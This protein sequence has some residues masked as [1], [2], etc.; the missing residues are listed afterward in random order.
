MTVV[1]VRCLDSHEEEE[2]LEQWWRLMEHL[3]RSSPFKSTLNIT[4][5]PKAVEKNRGFKDCQMRGQTVTAEEQSCQV[6]DML[7]FMASF[8]PDIAASAVIPEAKSLDWIYEFLLEHYG[9]ERSNEDLMLKLAP[10]RTLYR[11]R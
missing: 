10:T 9:H 7:E 8:M 2:E 3:I 6:E 1:P 11:D 4:W 5:I